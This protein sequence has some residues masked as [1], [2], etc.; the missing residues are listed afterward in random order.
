[1][2]VLLGISI[3]LNVLL[4]AGGFIL[5][6]QRDNLNDLLNKEVKKYT[7]LVRRFNKVNQ[8]M[9]LYD[10]LL[11]DTNDMV[12]I[13]CDI[14]NSEP[15]EEF[16]DVIFMCTSKLIDIAEEYRALQ[17][18]M[19]TGYYYTGDEEQDAKLLDGYELLEFEDLAPKPMIE[20]DEDWDI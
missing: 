12:A 2:L 19:T 13:L 8:K 6:K 10:Y 3:A 15:T 16:V 20:I 11:Y 7:D 17:D 14:Y 18:N 5:Y 1:M 9:H 4:F